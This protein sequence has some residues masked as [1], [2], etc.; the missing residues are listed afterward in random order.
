[1]L[2]ECAGSCGPL[3]RDVWRVGPGREGAE[4]VGRPFA[5]VSRGPEAGALSSPSAPCWEAWVPPWP[6]LQTT[7]GAG[8]ARKPRSSSQFHLSPWLLLRPSKTR[9]WVLPR[10]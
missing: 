10:T 7:P 5:W 3:S 8:K 9:P 6:W 1:M 4:P 2:S